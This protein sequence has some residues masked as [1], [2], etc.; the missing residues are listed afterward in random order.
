[1][2]SGAKTRKTQTYEFGPYIKRR[3]QKYRPKR[4]AGINKRGRL[5]GRQKN[6]SWAIE[7]GTAITRVKYGP[8]VHGLDKNF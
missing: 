1:M 2:S 4:S 6:E 7:M 3:I 5:V 8:R